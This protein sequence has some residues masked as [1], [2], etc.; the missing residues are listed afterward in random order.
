MPRE[1]ESTNKYRDL[2]KRRVHGS[3]D[4]GRLL[5]IRE[6]TGFETKMMQTNTFYGLANSGMKLKMARY[7]ENS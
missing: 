2:H 3:C 7:I 1:K 5:P 4:V 6:A